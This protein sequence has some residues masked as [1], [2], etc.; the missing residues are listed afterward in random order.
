MFL[1]SAQVQR[2]FQFK[3]VSLEHLQMDQRRQLLA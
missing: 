2:D 1:H 3:P